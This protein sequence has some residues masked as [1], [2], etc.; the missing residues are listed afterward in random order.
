[1]AHIVFSLAL[2]ILLFISHHCFLLSVNLFCYLFIQ[3]ANLLDQHFN[4]GSN[5]TIL[6]VRVQNA[7]HGCNFNKDQNM[8]RLTE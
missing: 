3:I 2:G 4:N 1:M 6:L 8:M 5:N 7:R